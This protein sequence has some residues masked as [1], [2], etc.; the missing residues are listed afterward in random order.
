MG[1]TLR[2]VQLRS[3]HSPSEVKLMLMLLE[4][5][6]GTSHTETGSFSVCEVSTSLALCWRCIS[7]GAIILIAT[8]LFS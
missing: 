5:N 3:E 6:A 1:D 2:A 7:E 4:L 8:K